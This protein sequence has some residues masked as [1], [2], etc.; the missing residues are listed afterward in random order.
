MFERKVRSAAPSS[1]SCLGS[2][3]M[4]AW[5]GSAPAAA[6]ASATATASGKAPEVSTLVIT[7][8]LKNGA[9][10]LSW[11]ATLLQ[12][13]IV[14]DAE[15]RAQDR[16]VA[17]PGRPAQADTGR[18]VSERR[19]AIQKRAHLYRR[20]PHRVIEKKPFCRPVRG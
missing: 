2:P 5:R 20:I 7:A 1:W 15:T 13:M 6:A 9:V 3:T 10:F 14:V 17:A 18:N 4:S 11:S 16:I 8:T 12:K 19:I